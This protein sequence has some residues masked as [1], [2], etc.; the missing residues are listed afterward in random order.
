[1]FL[2]IGLMYKIEYSSQSINKM[3]EAKKIYE[4]DGKSQVM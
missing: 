1:M 3:E 2:I 4:D